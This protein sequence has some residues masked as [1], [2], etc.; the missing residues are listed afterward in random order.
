MTREQ[1]IQ[2][3]REGVIDVSHAFD[4]YKKNKGRASF[5][6]FNRIINHFISMGFRLEKY[7]KHFNDEFA[8]IFVYRN[9]QL[10]KIN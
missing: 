10:I 3:I 5:E 1:W 9:D 7:I 8:V 6:N 4:F 2:N